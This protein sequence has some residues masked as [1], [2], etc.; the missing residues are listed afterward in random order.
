MPPGPVAGLLGRPR[1]GR[2]APVLIGASRSLRPGAAGGLAR[3]P[4][5]H[6]GRAARG[7]AVLRDPVDGPWAVFA[8]LPLAA[9]GAGR[10]PGPCNGDLHRGGA[11]LQA[12]A[13]LVPRR[14][15]RSPRRRQSAAADRFAGAG[16]TRDPLLLSW[17]ALVRPRSPVV[18]ICAH[19]GVCWCFSLGSGC[20]WRAPTPSGSLDAIGRSVAADI[21]PAPLALSPPVRGLL[22]AAAGR[23]VV[24]G[25]AGAAGPAVPPPGVLALIAP[26]SPLRPCVG[27]TPR[28]T[29]LGVATLPGTRSPWWPVSRRAPAN[30]R[31]AADRRPNVVRSGRYFRWPRPGRAALREAP[32]SAPLAHPGPTPAGRAP[33][34][35]TPALRLAMPEDFGQCRSARWSW[36]DGRTAGLPASST[37]AGRA[38][39]RSRGRALG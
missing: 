12:T 5:S 35:L 2:A 15:R 25:G 29:N 33:P 10:R 31:C 11:R 9:D 32:P 18:G 34:D 6:G 37:N 24:G 22:L 39:D 27:G 17:P 14:C 38:P 36:P 28:F 30:G 3:R 13:G 7:G 16:T 1:R 19:A 23:P 20:G 8:A 21:A 26:S 4:G